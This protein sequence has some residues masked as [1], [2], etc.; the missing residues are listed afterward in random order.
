M[1]VVRRMMLARETG[2]ADELA[3]QG[4][5][6][7]AQVVVTVATMG[8]SY[9]DGDWTPEEGAVLT[10]PALAD[11]DDALDYEGAPIIRSNPFYRGP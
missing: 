2:L 11:P 3:R 1:T 4:A 6:G 5:P 8:E 10:A 9:D 7:D